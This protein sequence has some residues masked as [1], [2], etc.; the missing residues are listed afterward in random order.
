MTYETQ[1]IL[2]MFLIYLITGVFA[3]LIAGMLG[4]GGGVVI[5]PIL[6]II[7]SQLALAPDATMQLAVGTS[8]ATIVFTSISSALTHYKLGNVQVKTFATLTPGIIVGA[9]IGAAVAD[10]LPTDTLRRSFGLFEMLVALQIGLGL[11][12][13]ARFRLPGQLGLILAGVM[14]GFI[15]AIM[16]IGGGSLTVPFL[17]F[18]HVAMK[19][20]VGTSSACGLP[21]AIA[22]VIGFVVMGLDRPDL[23]EWS[24]GYVY[25]PAA[26]GILITS[27]LFAPL[28]AKLADRLPVATL[29]RSFALVLGLIGL[30]M[31]LG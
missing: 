23:P 20:A 18:C 9:L 4:L 31:F 19:Q 7:F 10:S 24:L 2:S 8:L 22:G 25:L 6:F 13:P 30:K 26:A 1:I 28:G 15:S 17:I 14:I 29:K 27:V 12:P 11:K 21:I 16:G 5:V 3:G